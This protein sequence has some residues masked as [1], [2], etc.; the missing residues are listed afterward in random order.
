MIV[1]CDRNLF[2][3]CSLGARHLTR[4]TISCLLLE[5]A[6]ALNSYYAMSMKKES[7]WNAICPKAHKVGRKSF[8]AMHIVGVT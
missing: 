7:A 3:Q 2:E 5:G 8:K 4:T 6:Q 1:E